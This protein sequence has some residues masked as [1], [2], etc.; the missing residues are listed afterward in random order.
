[1]YKF[2]HNPEINL[3]DPPSFKKVDQTGGTDYPAVSGSSGWAVEESLDVEWAHA[4]APAANIILVEANS[5]SFSDMVGSTSGSGGAVQN[6][7]TWAGVSVISMSFGT[8]E[9]SGETAYDTY[10]TTPAGH[11]GIT[12]LAATGDSGAPGYYPA[13]SPNVLAVGETTLS[14]DANGDYVGETGWAWNTNYNPPWGG[15]GG[16]STQE[17]LPSYQDPG[18]VALE[19]YA[20]PNDES[21]SNRG[22][23]TF[24]S[25]PIPLTGV[26]ICD[27]YDY[28]SS[29]PWQQVGGTSLATPAG[30]D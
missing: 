11:T 25:T 29:A 30:P 21:L 7:R 6:A 17:P 27:S 13:Y 1:M 8:S 2:D 12:F 22:I 23:P 15:G 3:P 19:Y 28:G 16:Q 10:F 4:I 24:D 9:G 26:A 20:T 14:T 18:G 5:T